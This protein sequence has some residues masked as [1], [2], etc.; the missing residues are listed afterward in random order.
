MSKTEIKSSSKELIQIIDSSRVFNNYQQAL[1]QGL[2]DGDIFELATQVSEN[3]SNHNAKH[4][5]EMLPKSPQDILNS[6]QDGTS[7]FIYSKDQ[8]DELI[9]L[10]HGAIYPLFSDQQ[11]Q[12]FKWQVY[13][14]GTAITHPQFRGMGIGTKG[15][16]ARIEK[17]HQMFPDNSINTLG[18]STVKRQY[19]KKAL[20]NAGMHQAE[21]VTNPHIAAT[22]CVCEGLTPIQTGVGCSYRRPPQPTLIS[23]DHIQIQVSPD[24]QRA[25]NNQEIP[26]TL[27][28]SGL[29]KAAQFEQDVYNLYGS[30]AIKEVD[31]RI[32]PLD[33]ITIAHY[34]NI[35]E[36]TNV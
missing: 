36:L 23:P 18:I 32:N 26:C 17:M 6:I 27:M 5:Q 9:F 4:A 8:N 22:T 28:V 29:D 2:T 13:E 3:I 14:L 30:L 15:A 21:W 12:T 7:T 34:M 31:D 16:Q 24:S 19:T 11:V 25:S 33:L 35:Q 1:E 20:E 10:Y